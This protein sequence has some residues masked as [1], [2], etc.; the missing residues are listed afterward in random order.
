MIRCRRV[1]VVLWTAVLSTIVGAGCD[2]S[3]VEGLSDKHWRKRPKPNPWAGLHIKVNASLGELPWA[4]MLAA[5]P[6]RGAPPEG[7]LGTV[8]PV[9]L[10]AHSPDAGWAVLCQAREDTNGDGDIRVKLN[11]HGGFYGDA[12][13]PYLILGAGPGE[14]IDGY[15]A[16]DPTGRFVAIIADG[17]LVLVDSVTSRRTTL[18]SVAGGR[19]RPDP[20]MGDPLVSFDD[21]G[22]RMAYVQREGERSVAVLRDLST[23]DERV[24]DHGEGLLFRPVL[25]HR[26]LVLEVVAKD[27]DGNGTLELPWRRASLVSGRCRG[28]ASSYWAGGRS[29]DAVE[30]R[31][32]PVEGGP[33]QVV[34]GLVRPFGEGLLR[35][36]GEGAL[37]LTMGDRTAELVDESCNAWLNEVDP[38]R[39]VVLIARRDGE[40]DPSLELRGPGREPELLGEAWGAG[41]DRDRWHRPPRRWFGGKGTLHV[42]IIDLE[43][44]DRPWRG[45]FARGQYNLTL[46]GCRAAVGRGGGGAGWW[47]LRSLEGLG[48]EIV[49]QFH[50]LTPTGALLVGPTECACENWVEGGDGGACVAPEWGFCGPLHW[51]KF[52]PAASLRRELEAVGECRSAIY[53]RYGYSGPGSS[54]HRYLGERNC[55]PVAGWRQRVADELGDLE[56]PEECL[57]AR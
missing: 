9:Q 56:V 34:K 7:L 49:Q 57:G 55:V 16:H 40:D 19:E 45:G 23:G 17:Q 54:A 50:G 28:E 37:L 27:T 31:V 24:V 2:E 33:V 18:R 41:L 46:G 22:L 29:G 42:P 14:R 47:T 6:V 36:D 53:E 44:G 52:P 32:V 51:R 10:V 48:Y 43:T 20:L 35:R 12:M 25:Y 13:R 30:R 21:T 8:H 3:A 4:G 38:A 39:G 11:N 1:L 15:V 26:W 5:E